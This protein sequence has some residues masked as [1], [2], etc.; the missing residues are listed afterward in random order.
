MRRTSTARARFAALAACA[1]LATAC[2]DD[3]PSSDGATPTT[4][5][6]TAA[7][8][9]PCRVVDEAAAVAAVGPGAKRASGE[10]CAWALDEAR[11]TVVITRAYEGQTVAVV[12]PDAEPVD[13]LAEEAGWEALTM[14]DSGRLLLRRGG[15]LVSLQLVRPGSDQADLRARTRKVA[16]AILPVL[17]KVGPIP[18]APITTLPIAEECELLDIP[19]VAAALGVDEAD[20]AHGTDGGEGR[21]T[22]SAGETTVSLGPWTDDVTPEQFAAT[23]PPSQAIEGFDPGL[24]EVEGVGDDA[25]AVVFTS[26]TDAQTAQLAV[27]VGT[28]GLTVGVQNAPG[29]L[30]AARALALGV[31]ATG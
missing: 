13:G 5:A 16:E 4:V 20:V 14:V 29:A 25:F 7:V 18:P 11:L 12:A 31:I 2:S 9:D 6:F 22:F 15:A 17:G 23:R 26:G 1:L 28:R 8:T 3:G 24:V 21:C 27:L 10:G 30:D 19:A